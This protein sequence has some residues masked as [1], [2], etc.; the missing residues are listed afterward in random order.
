MEAVAEILRKVIQD[1][2]QLWRL[3]SCCRISAGGMQTFAGSHNRKAFL[4][5]SIGP[6][7]SGSKLDQV[8]SYAI[9][10]V[11][12]QVLFPLFSTLQ[13]EKERLRE[14]MEIGIR[15]IAAVVFPLL[16]LL[17]IVADPLVLALYH[18]PWLPCVH[19]SVFY[20]LAVCSHVC[21]TSIF[22]RLPHVVIAESFFGGVFIN[23][24]CLSP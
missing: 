6:L 2:V 22:T 3:S 10:Q 8:T 13:D 7:Y 4:G 17:I 20:V 23:G 24:G 15:V 11:L 1:V 12:V 19:I 21:R 16:I 18:E 14:M 5:I 9:P